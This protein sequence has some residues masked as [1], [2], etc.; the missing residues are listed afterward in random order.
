MTRT[1]ARQRC[2]DTG[3]TMHAHGVSYTELWTLF[4]QYDPRWQDC[5]D[6]LGGDY[7]KA[8]EYVMRGWD[9]AHRKATR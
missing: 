1:E 7:S 6:A 3:A 4:T 8:V 5:V 9:R 2:A